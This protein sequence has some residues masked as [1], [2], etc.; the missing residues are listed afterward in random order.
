MIVAIYMSIAKVIFTALF[1]Q[2]GGRSPQNTEFQADVGV[3]RVPLLRQQFPLSGDTL[4]IM[5]SPL[6]E[7]PRKESGETLGVFDGL[8]HLLGSVHPCVLCG[9]KI[10]P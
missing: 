8:L 9:S 3:P 5:H 4:W 7:G 10:L 2:R 6:M 1:P